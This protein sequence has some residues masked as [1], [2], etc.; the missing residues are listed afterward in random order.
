MKTAAIALLALLLPAQA[1]AQVV[2]LTL[3]CR[4][5]SA[6]EPLKAQSEAPVSG[7]FSAIVRMQTNQVATMDATT[8][9]CFD[10]V[11]T[12]N[13]LEVAGE[14]ER[15]VAS[16]KVKATLRINRISGAFE[17]DLT[18]GKSYTIFEGHCTPAKKLF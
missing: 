7:S 3:N 5:E 13:E 18:I 8:S 17:E 6:Y 11:G 14:C 4:Y 16:T 12:F 9:G 10:Y 2:E 1:R 15:D